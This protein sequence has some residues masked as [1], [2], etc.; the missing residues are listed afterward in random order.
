MR[1]IITGSKGMS[2]P[3]EIIGDAISA[4]KQLEAENKALKA[5][6]A[7]L[8]AQLPD[9][10]KHCTILF[11]ECE[12]GHGRLTATNWIDHGCPHCE[13]EGLKELNQQQYDEGYAHG[14][15]APQG[16]TAQPTEPTDEQVERALGA[17]LQASKTIATWGDCIRAA[18]RAA[19]QS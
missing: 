19:H 6:I 17:F 5:E 16:A 12:K 3:E 15:V 18:I 10:M 14:L 1:D 9:E 11:K 7:R 2:A 4:M 8:R 13:I